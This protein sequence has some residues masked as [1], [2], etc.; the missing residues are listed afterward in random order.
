M[1]LL[2]ISYMNSSFNYALT[3]CDCQLI[4]VRK[5]ILSVFERSGKIK[6]CESVHP[7]VQGSA[8]SSK[9]SSGGSGQSLSPGVTA[10]GSGD[11][12]ETARTLVDAYV[13]YK[14][15]LLR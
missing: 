9:R 7:H 6:S 15:G 11:R 2:Q 12:D 3:L 1:D 8:M 5:R 14:V 10:R 13:F 4:F